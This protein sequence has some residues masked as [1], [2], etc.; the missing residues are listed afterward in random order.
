MAKI[1]AGQDLVISINNSDVTLK[2]KVMQETERLFIIGLESGGLI[3]LDKADITYEADVK[4]LTKEEKRKAKKEY[5]KATDTDVVGV[6][7]EE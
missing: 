3:V 1:N 6:E 2:G 7:S 4:P 5:K